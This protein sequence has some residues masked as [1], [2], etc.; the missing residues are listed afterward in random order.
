M[1]LTTLLL[2]ATIEDEWEL[3]SI[4]ISIKTAMTVPLIFLRLCKE[5]REKNMQPLILA[6]KTTQ[7]EAFLYGIFDNSHSRGTACGWNV[8]L[9]QRRAEQEASSDSRDS[10]SRLGE[11]PAIQAC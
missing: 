10:L 4:Y 7:F 3:Q 11:L 8:P 5:C 9:L 2:V 6:G 1:N